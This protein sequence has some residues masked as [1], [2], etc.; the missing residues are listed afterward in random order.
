MMNFRNNYCFQSTI[1]DSSSKSLESADVV[2]T[3]NTPIV[4]CVVVPSINSVEGEIV[5]NPEPESDPISTTRTAEKDNSLAEGIV[6][7]R[8]N[9]VDDVL[10]EILV[11]PKKQV[12]NKRKRQVA[13]DHLPSVITSEK[14]LEIMAAKENEKQAKEEE[15]EIKKRER[16]ARIE[17]NK[18]IK[19]E[20]LEERMKKKAAK[21]PVQ[22]KKIK[23]KNK[24]IMNSDR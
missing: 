4:D 20:K 19:A 5:N 15:K 13:A 23:Y 17:E 9:S 7:G 11:W 3:N 1:G 18:R 2:N 12:S 24:E 8:P 10:K 14:W 22:K 21:Q 16:L 6:F